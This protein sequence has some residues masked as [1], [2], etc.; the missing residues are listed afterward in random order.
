MAS[1]KKSLGL[2]IIIAIVIII[3]L[4]GGIFG[5]KYYRMIYQPN[6]TLKGK[7]VDYLYIHTGAKFDDVMNMLFEKGI[8][9]D[10]SSFKWMAERKKYKDKVK[11]GRYLIKEDMS[12]NELINLLRSGKQEPVQLVFNNIR[13]KDQLAGRLAKQIEADSSSLI[14][15]FND[16]AFLKTYSLNPDNVVALFIPNTYEIKWNISAKQLMERMKKEFDKFWNKDRRQKASAINLN[17]VQVSILASIVQQETNK[18]DEM[19]RIAGVY[20]NRLE[21]DMKLEADPTVK[22]AIGDF[23]IKRILKRH[24]EYD[25]PYNTYMYKGLPPG[26][27]CIPTSITIDKV[28]NYE[29]HDFLFFCAKDDFSGYHVFAKTGA[30]HQENARKYQRALNEHNIKK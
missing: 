15:I 19:S 23:A 30:Q 22:F 27:I 10:T 14:D 5:F 11:P 17:P 6:V 18:T 16:G 28:L 1:K 20:I 21:K 24:L 26:P 13:T 2:K 12:N 9:I 7:Q 4:G 25:S 8:I 29:Q 3:I